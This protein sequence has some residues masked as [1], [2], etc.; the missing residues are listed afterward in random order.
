M[1]DTDPITYVD[2]Q[3]EVRTSY[4]ISRIKSVTPYFAGI[5]M[6]VWHTIKL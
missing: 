4:N 2:T 5:G 3:K 1:S 6:N